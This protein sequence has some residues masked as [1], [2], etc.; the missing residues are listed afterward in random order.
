VNYAI[1]IHD[2]KRIDR[3]LQHLCAGPNARPQLIN[4]LQYIRLWKPMEH[5]DWLLVEIDGNFSVR[6][7]QAAFAIEMIHPEGGENAV[8]QL[9]M[10]EGKSSVSY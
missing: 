1:S 9:N 3:M 10:G 6:P 8:M 4:E 5:P 2:A 7:A